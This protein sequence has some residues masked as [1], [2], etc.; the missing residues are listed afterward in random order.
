MSEV[1]ESVIDAL[2]LVYWYLLEIGLE[3]CI[4]EKCGSRH[5][6]L[7]NFNS[8][9]SQSERECHC[10]E[11]CESM[12]GQRLFEDLGAEEADLADAFQRVPLLGAIILYSDL[13]FS[14]SKVGQVKRDHSSAIGITNLVGPTDWGDNQQSQNSGPSS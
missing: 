6:L 9:L 14:K 7:D 1:C 10:R 11:Y 8:D 12:Y 3:T 2:S 5:D 4:A 13:Y